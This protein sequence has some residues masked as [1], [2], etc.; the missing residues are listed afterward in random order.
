LNSNKDTTIQ[1]Y[2]TRTTTN[3][4]LVVMFYLA[5][6]FITEYLA[7]TPTASTSTH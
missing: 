3:P 7:D 2:I 1:L 5:Y 4:H 6:T